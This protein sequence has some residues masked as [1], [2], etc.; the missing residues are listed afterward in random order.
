MPTYKSEFLHELSARGFIHQCS[1]PQKLDALFQNQKVTAYI[2]F[3]CTA[4]SLHVG[5]MVQIM[6]L[7]WLQKFGHRPVVLMG[8]GTTRIGDPSDKD[9]MRKILTP[10]VIEENKRSLINVFNS[11]LDFSLEDKNSKAALSVDNADWLLDLN[12]V[13]FLREIGRHFSVN[14]MLAFE[15]V[16][17][18]LDRE[19]PLSFLEFNYMIL[20]A[21]DFVELYRRHG[22]QVQIGG[23][24][25]WGNIVSGI[26]LGRRTDGAEL[27]GLTTP[28]VTTASGA[29]MGKTASGAV[30][31]NPQMRTPYEYWQFWRSTQDDDVGKFLRLFTTLPL[32]EIARLEK[33]EGKELNG[34]KENLATEATTLLHGHDAA[35]AAAQT[36]RDTFDGPG[37]SH[38]LP[39]FEIPAKSLS[40]GLGLLAA[41]VLSELA[42]SNSEARRHIKGGALKVNDAQ[43]AHEKAVLTQADVNSHGVIKLSVGKKR[44]ALLKPV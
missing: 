3:D 38:G 26:D 40:A 10:E 42:A 23:S 8:G 2:G 32:D 9:E 44:H 19:Q 6:V 22:C 27:F 15:G 14:R 41:T 33:L 13:D 21:F 24:D 43:A 36:A 20:Q 12:Y 17:R 18:R 34:A 1:D 29:K 39:T 28:L 25:Q 31:L 37:V 16:K 35:A 7:H 30:W 5:S 11:F 4:K